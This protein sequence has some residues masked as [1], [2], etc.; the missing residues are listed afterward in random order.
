VTKTGTGPCQ[1]KLKTAAGTA[2]AATDYLG[3]AEPVTV[4]FDAVQTTGCATLKVYPDGAVEPPE[5]LTVW[6]VEPQGCTVS[7]GKCIITIA[8]TTP[9]P[10]PPPPPLPKVSVPATATVK[11]G[12]ALSLTVT[13]TGTGACSFKL[14]TTGDTAKTTADYAGYDPRLGMSM[15][16]DQKTAVASLKVM[17]DTLAEPP[18]TLRISIQE[19]VG[20]T[21]EQAT[22]TVTIQDVQPKI[23]E[24]PPAP[25]IEEPAP[26][27]EPQPEDPEPGPE[28][29]VIEDPVVVEPPPPP[30]PPPIPEPLMAKFPRAKGF[31]TDA[32]AAT[33]QAFYRVTS[34]DDSGAGTLRDALAK[35]NRLIVF[36]VAGCIKLKSS[37]IVTGDNTTIAGQTA[38]PPGI[39]VQHKEL[40]VKASNVRIQHLTFERGYDPGDQGNADVV[41]VSPGSGSSV[42]RRS[43]IHFDHCAFLWGTDETVE[44]WPSGGSLSNVS[45][46]DC[47]FSEP[48]WRPQKLGYK[49]HEKV[50]SGA[51]GEHNYGLLIGYNTQKV[52]IQHC[53][54]S[55]MYFRTPFIDHGT[56]T[57]I[58]NIALLNVRMGACIHFGVAPPPSKPC[59]VNAQGI[60]CISGPQS[61]EHTGFRFHRYP[62]KWPS[63]S[64]VYVSNLYGWKGENSTVT[65]GTS[66]TYS[67]IEPTQGANNTKVLASTPPIQPPGTT[68]KPLTAQQIYDRLLANCGPFPKSTARNPTVVRVINKLRTKKGG[69][70]DHES[71]VGGF[72]NYKGATRKL[73]DVRM[74]DGTPVPVPNPADTASVQKWLNV[75]TSLVS[76]D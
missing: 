33:G 19:P 42:W 25:P 4:A 7:Q 59:L 37:L 61:G 62:A 12:E 45:F 76:N 40:Q 20:C 18:E 39:T 44:I 1:V 36:E 55:D 70:V 15:A 29:D 24:P 3:Y 9:A 46:T 52:D 71:Q 14:K 57:V 23:P 21:V 35:P 69:W 31:A 58:A 67:G 11:E 60:L 54:F 63:G 5:T 28:P 65:P 48:L 49:A 47:L 50:A 53:L 10:P 41:K 72:S 17:A 51:Q 75:L 74:P 26:P 66:V 8:D 16:K 64:A 6:V 13:K 38:P 22:C 43:N 73:E 56:S 34:L 30:P 27:T 32:R 2:S 68:V